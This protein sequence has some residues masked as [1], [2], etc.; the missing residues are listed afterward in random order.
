MTAMVL[1]RSLNAAQPMALTIEGDGSLDAT[2]VA[3]EW[4][5]DA[6]AGLTPGAESDDFDPM[7]LRAAH[8]SLQDYLHYPGAGAGWQRG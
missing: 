2:V 6:P 7:S 1:T 4:G 8:E 3:D 5:D